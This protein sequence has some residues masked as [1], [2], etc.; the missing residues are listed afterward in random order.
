M[1]AARSIVVAMLFGIL[2]VIVGATSSASM[3]RAPRAARSASSRGVGGIGGV[4]GRTHYRWWDDAGG[5]GGDEGHFRHNEYWRSHC[6]SFP[7]LCQ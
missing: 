7:D 3:P 6:R 2:A 1:T 4:G 5:H